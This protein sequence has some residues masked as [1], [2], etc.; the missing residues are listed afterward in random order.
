L[1]D[2]ENGYNFGCIFDKLQ[3]TKGKKFKNSSDLGCIFQN[4]KNVRDLLLENF[5]CDFPVN[6]IIYRTGD[7][8]KVI[9]DEAIK[10]VEQKKIMT[11]KAATS[12]ISNPDKTLI[13]PTEEK[14][15]KTR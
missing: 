6:N 12:I 1:T 7:L 15:F 9:R 11:M 2:F 5:G 10:Y 4:Y 3:L 8:L 14:L 13:Q